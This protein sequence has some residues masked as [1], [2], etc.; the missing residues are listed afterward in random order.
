[1]PTEFVVAGEHLVREGNLLVVTRGELTN[2]QPS[3]S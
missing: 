2:L 3:K 1:M